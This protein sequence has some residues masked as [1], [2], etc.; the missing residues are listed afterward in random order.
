MPVPWPRRAR[1]AVSGGKS[2]QTVDTERAVTFANNALAWLAQKSIPP[3]PENFELIYSYYSGDHGDLRR[4]VDALIGNGCR[5]DAGVMSIL[6]QRYFRSANV[7]QAVAE[8]G[9]KITAE[10]D[11]VLQMLE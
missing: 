4:A 10:L 3:T 6:H 1:V 11:S 5:F 7:D 9:E 2:V 8:V